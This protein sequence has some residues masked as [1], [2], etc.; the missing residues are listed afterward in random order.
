MSVVFRRD[1]PMDDPVFEAVRRLVSE[2]RIERN[3][4]PDAVVFNP[5]VVDPELEPGEVPTT[6]FGIRVGFDESV[7]VRRVEARRYQ[8]LGSC[9][10]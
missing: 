1:M 10:L 6:I 2:V 9:E 7:P 5:A 4:E 3:R 8:V